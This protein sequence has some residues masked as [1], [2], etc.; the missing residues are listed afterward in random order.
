MDLVLALPV[1]ELAT[2]D[3]GLATHLKNKQLRQ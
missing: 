3:V 1:A 2:G